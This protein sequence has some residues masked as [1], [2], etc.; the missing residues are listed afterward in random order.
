[1]YGGMQSEVEQLKRD[2]LL[3]LKEVMRL[4]ESSAQTADEVRSLSS[5]LAQTEAMQAQMLSFLQQHI[6]PTLLNANSHILQGRKRR[7]LLMAPS[8]PLLA[9]DAPSLMSV[10]PMAARDTLPLASGVG[11]GARDALPPFGDD[12]L[13]LGGAAGGVG[14]L[15]DGGAPLLGPGGAPSLGGASPSSSRVFLRELPDEPVPYSLGGAPV[16]P[17]LDTS[18]PYA[19]GTGSAPSDALMPSYH[20]LLPPPPLPDVLQLPPLPTPGSGGES[21]IFS[22]SDLD[23]LLPPAGG[24]LGASASSAL[25]DAPLDAGALTRLNSADINQI[26]REMQLDGPPPGAP[27]VRGA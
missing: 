4:R 27:L 8:N 11:L 20:P 17:P 19:R 10:D 24:A 12:A 13:L 22:W 21:D 1:M 5:R 26:V 25:P 15:G 7:H 2:R 3:L 16:A 6:S 23:A 18:L 9:D 14:A